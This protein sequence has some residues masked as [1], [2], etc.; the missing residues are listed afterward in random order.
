MSFC[1]FVVAAIVAIE[2]IGALLLINALVNWS[3]RK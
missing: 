3:V 1:D 2:I